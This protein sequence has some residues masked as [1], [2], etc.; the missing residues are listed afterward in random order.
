MEF[1][2]REPDINSS[3]GVSAIEELIENV[4]ETRFE[5]FDGVTIEQ[6]KA[7]IIDVIGCLIAGVKAPGNTA[8]V[9]LVRDWGGKEEATILVHGVKALCQ[10]V[11]MVNCIMARSYDYEPNT[12]LVDGKI[13]PSHLSGT[14]I[15]TAITVGEMAGVSGRE[16]ITAILAGENMATRILAAAH[17]EK[18]LDSIGTVNVFGAT[19]IAGRLIGLNKSQMMNAMGICLDHVTG[20]YQNVWDRTHSFKLSQGLSARSGVFS[21]QL[22]KKGWTATKDALLG[23][24]A[25]YYLHFNDINDI[26]ILTNDLGEK[27]YTD[28][29]FKPYPSCRYNHG[30]VECVLSLMSNHQI[31]VENIK[32]VNVYVSRSGLQAAVSKPFN[33]GD[34]PYVDSLFSYQ[35]AVANTLLRKSIKLEHFSDEFICNAEIDSIISKINL[36][37]LPNAELL[38][39]KVDIVMNDGRILSEYVEAPKGDQDKNPMSKDEILAKFWANVEFSNTLKKGNAEKSLRLLDKLEEVEHIDEIIKFLVA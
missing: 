27:Y 12:A 1:P 32:E 36:A 24:F 20:H 39:A 14:T 15:M 38:E 29:H 8:L 9:E 30:P 7:R 19:A 37:E 2:R 17:S 3:K 25:Y 23:K 11:A 21:A 22:A 28:A 33:V 4:L 35:Y 10:N 13:T 31:H 18:R 6:A 26:N 34:S 16:L 5:D